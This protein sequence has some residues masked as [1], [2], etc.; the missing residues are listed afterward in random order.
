ME[1]LGHGGLSVA[2]T[3]QKHQPWFVVAVGYPL[4][5][6]PKMAF[7]LVGQNVLATAFAGFFAT[8]GEKF[9]A[10]PF[11]SERRTKTMCRTLRLGCREVPYLFYVHI[12]L[13]IDY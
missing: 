12:C 7:D 10:D 8:L 13:H 3:T 5:D 4:R 1:T 11:Q 9:V 6:A 2:D